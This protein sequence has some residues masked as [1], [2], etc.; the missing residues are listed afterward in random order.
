MA[1]MASMA[2]YHQ[3]QQAIDRPIFPCPYC[4]RSFRRP[5]DLKRHKCNGTRSKGGSSTGGSGQTSTGPASF[6]CHICGRGFNRL[7]DYLRQRGGW[8]INYMYVSTD[9]LWVGLTWLTPPLFSTGRVI[10]KGTS[11][12]AYV[13]RQV[14]SLRL[15]LS[16][17]SVVEP[18]GEVGTSRD[19]SATALGV[20]PAP[21]PVPEE[22]EEEEEG[23]G[24][25]DRN[26]AQL[27][28]IY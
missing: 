4:Q 13:V 16:V 1:T 24:R 19:T 23:K 22:W 20:R 25:R 28:F 12:I 10:S 11:V 27:V 9:R 17:K 5:G 3:P 18:S 21:L 7:V 8:I 2:N 14:S 26:R 15:L 6:K